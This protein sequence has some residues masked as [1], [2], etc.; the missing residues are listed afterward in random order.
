MQADFDKLDATVGKLAKGIKDTLDHCGKLFGENSPEANSTAACLE[1]FNSSSRRRRSPAVSDDEDFFGEDAFGSGDYEDIEGSGDPDFDEAIPCSSL[2]TNACEA[3]QVVNVTLVEISLQNET[4]S[5]TF[6]EEFKRM[7][8]AENNPIERWCPDPSEEAAEVFKNKTNGDW[9]S[10]NTPDGELSYW[11][12]I[13]FCDPTNGLYK[14]ALLKIEEAAEDLKPE[15]GEKKK[16]KKSKRAVKETVKEIKDLPVTPE[17]YEESEKAMKKALK[18]FD[19]YEENQ[20][21]SFTASAAEKL[22]NIDEHLN[23]DYSDCPEISVEE[24]L[25]N[26]EEMCPNCRSAQSTFKDCKAKDDCHCN[27]KQFDGEIEKTKVLKKTADKLAKYQPELD[28]LLVKENGMIS[29]LIR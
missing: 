23:R 6:V 14:R 13:E 27:L 24:F 28:D 3:L 7:T 11:D 10:I 8:D 20:L 26:Y 19:Q 4:T 25:E 9:L 18:K 16:S 29:D 22:K 2:D 17:G 12:S 15:V 1:K 5:E 21:K